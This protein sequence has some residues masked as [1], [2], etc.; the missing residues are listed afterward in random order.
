MLSATMQTAV[1]AQG[2]SIGSLVLRKVRKHAQTRTGE[3]SLD[4]QGRDHPS[5]ASCVPETLSEPFSPVFC[6]H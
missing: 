4:I 5:G 2:T 6:R 1:R 3:E